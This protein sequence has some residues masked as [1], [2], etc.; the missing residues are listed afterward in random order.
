[1]RVAI[2]LT[3]EDGAGIIGKVN[4]KSGLSLS[5]DKSTK[6]AHFPGVYPSYLE[7]AEVISWFE[8]ALAQVCKHDYVVFVR[9]EGAK[10]FCTERQYALELVRRQREWQTLAAPLAGLIKSLAVS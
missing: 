5:F 4:E 6:R 8:G 2:L 10:D 9:E 7:A 1:M 3:G